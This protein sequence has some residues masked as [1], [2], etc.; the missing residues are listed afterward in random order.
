MCARGNPSIPSSQ[1]K[2][3]FW[4]TQDTLVTSNQKLT[5]FL[6]FNLKTRTWTDLGPK[7]VGNIV[8]WM[9]SPDS[10]YLYFT[11]ARRGTKGRAH[12]IRR[13]ADRN[14]RRPERLSSCAD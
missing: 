11:T 2:G 5:G 6:T 4:E 8:N 3:G 12:P 13:P 7:D 1:G 14:H 9:I 10:K